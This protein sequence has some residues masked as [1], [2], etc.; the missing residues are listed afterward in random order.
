MVIDET[1]TWE[2]GG[3]GWSLLW[4]TEPRM[5]LALQKWLQECGLPFGGGGSGEVLW[6]VSQ[7]F[8]PPPTPAGQTE[9]GGGLSGCPEGLRQKKIK[10]R[11]TW[12][13]SVAWPSEVQDESSLSALVPQKL[14]LVPGD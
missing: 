9:L 4:G 2:S 7:S 6:P 12:V 10:D 13:V 5:W 14:C 3:S 11:Q 8:A 1:A